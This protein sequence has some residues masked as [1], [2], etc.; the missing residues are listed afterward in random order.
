M[1]I[2]YCGVIAVAPVLLGGTMRKAAII[3]LILLLSGCTIN[4]FSSPTA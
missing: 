4:G 2:V 3:G 1:R